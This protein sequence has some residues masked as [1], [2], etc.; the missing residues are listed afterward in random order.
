MC[1]TKSNCNCGCTA[2][3]K[4]GGVIPRAYVGMPSPVGY[5]GLMGLS[6]KV[7]RGL[8]DTICSSFDDEGN[9]IGTTDLSTLPTYNPT[10]TGPEPTYTP[11]I[12]ANVNNPS[13][14]NWNSIAQAWTGITGQ[15]LKSE[16]GANPT[17]QSVSPNGASTTIYG[18]LPTNLQASLAQPVAGSLSLGSLLLFGGIG[19][20]AI[21]VL[22]SVSK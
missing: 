9:C 6:G 1:A 10:Y 11:P 12:T 18:S 5:T 4:I 16:A 20:A 7:F 2:I 17:Y 8:G 15:I 3:P 21:L 19:I 13:G 14:I 22:K